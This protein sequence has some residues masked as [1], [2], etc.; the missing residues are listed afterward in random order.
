MT[1]YTIDG[2]QNTISAGNG[3]DIFHGTAGGIDSLRGNGGNDLFMIE[4]GQT[5]LID[6]GAGYDRV[7]LQGAGN[8]VLDAGLNIV[9]VEEMIVDS[10]N[11][12]ATV[13]QLKD[14][15]HFGVNNEG[16]TFYFFLQGAGGTLDFSKSFTEPQ[17][18]NIEANMATSRVVITGNDGKNE[19]IGSDFGDWLHGGKG[20]DTIHGGDGNDLVNG[21]LG[22]D[23]L[24]GD[25]GRDVFVFNTALLS[26]NGNLDHIG[27]FRPQDDSIRIDDAIF[28]WTGQAL[29]TIKQSD[30]KVIG[31]GQTVDAN[32][33]IL[34]NQNN[35][36]IY[37]D[38]DGAGGKAAVLF[39]IADNFS[40]D[41]PILTY[42]DFIII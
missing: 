19:I 9:G 20:N 42:Q 14:V 11:L 28:Q 21:G 26:G 31:N 15:T 5:G 7:H 6:G 40:G 10:T 16:E 17:L 36:A 1:T 35:G 22:R 3:T 23:T 41:V 32:D 24:Y 38:A 37:Y 12:T 39:A 33:H 27:D 4:T 18:L 29:G 2:N 30:F 8:N 13:A 34:Y 25:D